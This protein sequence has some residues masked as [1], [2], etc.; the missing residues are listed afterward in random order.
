MEYRTVVFKLDASDRPALPEGK[1]SKHARGEYIRGQQEWFERVT[2]PV[3]NQAREIGCVAL[4]QLWHSGE[5]MI[6]I[7]QDGFDEK[8][9]TLQSAIAVTGHELYVPRQPLPDTE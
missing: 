8:V 3:R 1:I 4:S 2:E 9:Q 6:A 7:P 5:I